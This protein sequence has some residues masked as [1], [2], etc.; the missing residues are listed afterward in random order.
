M[1]NKVVIYLKLL[2]SA[3]S[4]FIDDDATKLSASLAYYTIFSIAPLLLVLITLISVFFKDISTQFQDQIQ[5]LI[6]RNGAEQL[7]AIL[8]NIRH[9]GHTKIVGIIGGIVLVFGATGVFTEIQSSIN[10]IWSIRA[11]PK[12]SWVKYLTNR[13]LSFSLIIGMGF[14]LIVS[15]FINTLLDLMTGRLKHFFGDADVILVQIVSLTTLFV[16]ITFLFAVIYK[17]LPDARIH[18]RDALVGASFT[19]ILFLIGKFLIS[20]YLAKSKL[21]STYGA[22]AS[23]IIILSW[24]YYSSL[25]LYFGAEFTK[26][27][28]LQVGKGISPY[29]TA[30]FIIKRE[31]KELKNSSGPDL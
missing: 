19:G 20:Y 28:A 23:I 21:D 2:K 13:F 29:S 5:T 8:N 10:Y 26:V 18:W 27:Y 31:A 11:K 6:G 30:V 7:F 15:L 9:Q 22:A 24:V 25:I 3:G 12:N 16:V 1:A 4:E 17:I 14:L